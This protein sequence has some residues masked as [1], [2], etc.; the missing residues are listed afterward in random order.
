MEYYKCPDCSKMYSVQW[1]I[2]NDWE[3]SDMKGFDLPWVLCS[4]CNKAKILHKATQQE[5]EKA[6]EEGKIKKEEFNMNVDELKP[7][8]MPVL[9]ITPFIGKKVKIASVKVEESRNPAITHPHLY[10]ETEVVTKQGDKEVRASKILGL[11]AEKKADG[12]INVGWA[13]KGKTAAFLIAMN[14]MQPKDLVGKE[15]ILLPQLSKDGT[16][17]YLTF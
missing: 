9:D 1:L 7:I 6:Y 5:V 2:D 17:R 4:T 15:V 8:D 12:T 3:P 11:F 13:K 10:V 14:V 16:R